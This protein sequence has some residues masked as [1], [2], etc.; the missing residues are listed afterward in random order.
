MGFGASMSFISMPPHCSDADAWLPE[1]GD[2]QIKGIERAAHHAGI[3][4]GHE[5]W[6]YPAHAVDF[7]DFEVI[8]EA[9]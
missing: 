3:E 4:H 7:F 8:L 1:L 2:V 9:V 6:S 5:K